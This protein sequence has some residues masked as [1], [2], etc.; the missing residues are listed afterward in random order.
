VSPDRPLVV[1]PARLAKGL[2]FD[3]VI[4]AEPAEIAVEEPHGARLL[5]VA[6]T[7]AVQHLALAH[8]QPLPEVLAGPETPVGP[9][10]LGDADA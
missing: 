7:R 1:L 3:A 2:E 5:F 8:A 4:V 10:L 9:E 6:L